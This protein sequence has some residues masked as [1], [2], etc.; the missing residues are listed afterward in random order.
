MTKR[1]K[2]TRKLS[3]PLFAQRVPPSATR[4]PQQVAARRDPVDEHAATELVMYIENESDLSPDGPSGQGRSVLLNAL[5]K[6]KKG[7]YDPTQAVRLFEYLAEAGAKRY[8]KEFGSSPKEWSTMFTPATRHEAAKQLEASFRNSAEHGEY[9]HVDTRV[10]RTTEIEARRRP[11]APERSMTYPSSPSGQYVLTR[12]GQEIIRGTEEEIWRWMH[13]NH[14]YSI[15]HALRY[16]G[17]AIA[18]VEN[19]SGVRTNYPRAPRQGHVRAPRLDSFTNAYFETALWSSTDES[20]DQGG[21]PLDENY[22]VEDIAPETR[23]KMIAD[24]A[25]FQDRYADLLTAAE[26]IDSERAGHNF[27]LS[28]NGHGAGFFDDDLDE[29]QEAAKSYGEFNLYV[30][31]DGQIHG[32]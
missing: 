5:R 3:T 20:N 9:D 19:V 13:R 18:P 29:L 27:W 2:K 1:K 14:S 25:D 6:W 32:S 8:A 12:D 23:A 31:D 21:D 11:Q 16:E 4:E 24:C 10:A 15:N 26:N 7:T 30:G 22:N 17:Y 28:R